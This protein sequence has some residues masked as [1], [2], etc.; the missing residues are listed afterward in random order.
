MKKGQWYVKGNEKELS[1]LIHELMVNVIDADMGRNF[2]GKENWRVTI[3]IEQ[4]N[5]PEVSPE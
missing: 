5:I 2:K 3:C 1:N 4:L